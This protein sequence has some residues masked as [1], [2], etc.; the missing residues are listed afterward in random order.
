MV[1]GAKHQ[2]ACLV[3]AHCFGNNFRF[4][5]M[6]REPQ[7]VALYAVCNWLV[8]INAL[9]CRSVPSKEPD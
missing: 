4:R 5:N 1:T 3:K 8:G 2:K 7:R 6:L 9:V